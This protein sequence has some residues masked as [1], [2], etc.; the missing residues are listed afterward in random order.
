[1]KIKFLNILAILLILITDQSSCQRNN[2]VVDIEQFIQPDASATTFRCSGAIV[3][4]Q[5]VVATANCATVEL[6]YELGVRLRTTISEGFTSN[7]FS[8]TMG[9]FIHP[10]YAERQ[11]AEFN[12]ALIRVSSTSFSCAIK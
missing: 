5:H 9:A 8:A 10:E 4:T 3:S 2:H 11:A 6:P 1:M 7:L 12:V